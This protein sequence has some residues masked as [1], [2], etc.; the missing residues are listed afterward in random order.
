[1]VASRA[2]W[3][4]GSF[5]VGR[6]LSGS[7]CMP[8]RRRSRS[9]SSRVLASGRSEGRSRILVCRWHCVAGTT[10]ELVDHADQLVETMPGRRVRVAKKE[11]LQFTQCRMI[12]RVVAQSRRLKPIDHRKFCGRAEL[13]HTCP[14]HVLPIP[15]KR[16]ATAPIDVAK[17][18]PCSI[19][20]RAP[21]DWRT[22]IQRDLRSATCRPPAP[23]PMRHSPARWRPG[24]GF[25]SLA[26]QRRTMRLRRGRT[27]R[28]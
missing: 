6:P 5:D 27:R 22:P 23:V 28:T 2:R 16:D 11:L 9:A 12:F 15:G 17:T 20:M 4:S 19:P 24:G 3:H 18:Q 14:D 26:R 21:S 7:A 25:R 8:Y 10:V 13:L 1:M